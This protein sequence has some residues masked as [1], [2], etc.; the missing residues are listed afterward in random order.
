MLK[1]EVD[2]AE[3]A[4]E[5]RFAFRVCTECFKKPIFRLVR[6]AVR[7]AQQNELCSE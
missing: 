3:V 7:I 2:G 4:R 1:H 5:D 6:I